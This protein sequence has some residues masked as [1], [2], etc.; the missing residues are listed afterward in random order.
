[1]IAAIKISSGFKANK[2]KRLKKTKKVVKI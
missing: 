2:R 1:M